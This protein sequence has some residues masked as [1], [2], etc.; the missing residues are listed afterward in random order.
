[1]YR[2]NSFDEAVE[3]AEQLIEDGGLGHTAFLCKYTHRYR[4]NRK[5]SHTR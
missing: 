2:A 3:K 1:M 4:K 5:N